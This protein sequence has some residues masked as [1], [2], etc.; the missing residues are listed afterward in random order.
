MILA[1][2]SAPMHIVYQHSSAGISLDRRFMR[3]SIE[4]YDGNVY[5]VR[6]PNGTWLMRYH[7]RTCWT[8]NCDHPDSSVVSYKNVSH[9]II[10]AVMDH[11]G[12]VRG[13]MKV[14]DTPSGK[15]LQALIEGDVQIGI[16]SRGVGS[17]RKQGDYV[18]VQE[19]FQLIC[20]DAVSEPSTPSAFMLPEGKALPWQLA[21]GRPLTKAERIDRL[22]AE[23]LTQ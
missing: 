16:S 5:C 17:T 19:D 4:D 23:M 10:E 1:E 6:V 15:I 18:V 20:W 7:G 9:M 11:D 14:L 8:G 12:V 13:R 3:S 2:N 21:E 22:I